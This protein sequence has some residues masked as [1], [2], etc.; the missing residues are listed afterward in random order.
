MSFTQSKCAQVHETL[1]A[2]EVLTDLVSEVKPAIKILVV[3]ISIAHER[4][5]DLPTFAGILSP[6]TRNVTVILFTSWHVVFRTVDRFVTAHCTSY[7]FAG[8]F[9]SKYFII[10]TCAPCFMQHFSAFQ[11]GVCRIICISQHLPHARIATV[12]VFICAMHS[13]LLTHTLCITDRT[14][15]P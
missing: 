15:A 8:E 5:P 6:Q 1:G 2:A 9:S 10:E 13:A 7:T 11:L 14:F 4:I 12:F 3:V